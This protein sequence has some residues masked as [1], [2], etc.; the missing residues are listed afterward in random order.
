[1]TASLVHLEQVLDSQE[2]ESTPLPEFKLRKLPF[3][4][5]FKILL[6]TFKI[7]PGEGGYVFYSIRSLKNIIVALYPIVRIS[8]KTQD[9]FGFNFH[10]EKLCFM[11]SHTGIAWKYIAKCEIHLIFILVLF[12]GIN[13]LYSV[14]QCRSSIDTTLNSNS[15][16]CLL[17]ECPTKHKGHKFPKLIS[18]ECLTRLF[19]A[20]GKA[21][22][23]KRRGWLS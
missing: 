6:Q 1:M 16:V 22:E 8:G 4:T 21:C 20:F 14:P 17:V 9:G 13:S 7:L 5:P 23:T 3:S 12:L 10:V 19:C 15:T 2:D 11:D 18:V